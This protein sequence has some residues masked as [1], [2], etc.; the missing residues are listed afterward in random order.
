MLMYK[1]SGAFKVLHFFFSAI[2]IGKIYSKGILMYPCAV[3]INLSYSEEM[4]L[5]LLIQA[6]EK[7]HLPES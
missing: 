6:S 3:I 4:L 7:N 2:N 5:T 1:M